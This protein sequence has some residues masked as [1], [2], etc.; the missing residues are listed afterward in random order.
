M[1][2]SLF[3]VALALGIGAGTAPLHAEPVRYDIDPTHVTVAFLVEHIGYADTLGLFRE[4]EG[5]FFYDPETRELGEVR[6]VVNAASVFT[7]HDARD[8]HVRNADFL[9]ASEFPEIVFTANGGEASS[10]TA[11]TVT[12]ELT[13]LGVTKPLTLDVTLNKVAEYPFG[14]KRQTVGAS[15]RGTVMRSAYGMTY[16]LGGIVGDEVELIIE[17]EGVLA[18]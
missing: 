16:A 3:A 17:I 7:N 5:Y 4:V 11:G 9:N 8:E 15:A 13:V 14:H 12:G 6:I 2:P 1:R 18:Q 10:D